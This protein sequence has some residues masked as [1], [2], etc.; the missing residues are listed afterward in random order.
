PV[1]AQKLAQVEVIGQ[2]VVGGGAKPA[3]RV[4]VDPSLL[5][6]LGI[7]LEQVRAGLRSVNANAPKGQLTD[8]ATSWTIQATDQLFDADEYRPVI[9]AW[10]NGAPVRLGDLASV[11]SSVE[12]MRAAGVGSGKRDG[13]LGG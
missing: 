11:E 12:D 9:V 2:V 3:V 13:V 4:R 6:Q 1:L 10:Q 8:A 7:G 5:T